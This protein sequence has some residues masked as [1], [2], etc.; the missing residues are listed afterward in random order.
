MKKLLII[1]SITALFIIG[2]SLGIVEEMEEPIVTEE[3]KIEEQE[4]IIEETTRQE[5]TIT[6]GAIGDVL[7]HERVYVHAEVEEGV[8]D[9]MPMLEKVRHLLEGPDFLMANMESIPGG[10]E[11]GLSTYPAF[12]SPQEIVSNLQ[13]L[14]VDMVIGANNHTLDRG[15]KAVENAINFYDEIAMP[16]V[17]KYRSLED[18]NRD[19]IVDVDGITV[20]V[21]AYTYGTN[22]IPVPEGHEYVVALIEQDRIGEDI[23]RLRDKVDVLLVHMH[24]GDEYQLEPNEEQRNLAM[25]LAESGV[26]IVFGHHPHVLQPIELIELENGHQTT[27]FYSL[28]NF[29]SGQN[30]E[31]TDIGGVATIEVTKVVEDGDVTLNIHSPHIEPTLVVRTDNGYFVGPMKNAD[32]PSI[33]GSTYEEMVEHTQTYLR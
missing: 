28:G 18:R 3:V 30:F 5:T 15:L 24:W 1:T 2:C 27:V 8:Y 7:L 19:R 14:G 29:F 4:E 21:L 17:G 25:L 16:Y 9:F 32:F 11:I 13:S 33:S 26:D 22:G 10:V 31:Y 12:N 6:I 20:G 23:V